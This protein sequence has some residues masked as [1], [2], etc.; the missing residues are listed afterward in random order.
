MI[1]PTFPAAFALPDL[2][3]YTNTMVTSFVL[4]CYGA[5]PISFPSSYAKKEAHKQT[6]RSS[7]CAANPDL[8]LTTPTEEAAPI[9]HS[10]K[11][12]P[13]T[14]NGKHGSSLLSIDEYFRLL[15]YF[16]LKRPFA[17]RFFI[18]LE[19]LDRG[20]NGIRAERHKRISPLGTA[21]RL[22]VFSHFPWLSL[23][24]DFKLNA[25]RMHFQ[26]ESFFLATYK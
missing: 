10:H 18:A 8:V 24:S 5:W 2:N 26:A 3:R 16:S 1:P 13:G 25:G 19:I 21:P 7:L 17:Q 20:C 23:Y 12:E 11:A 9:L 15:L 14:V 6:V 22:I 4:F